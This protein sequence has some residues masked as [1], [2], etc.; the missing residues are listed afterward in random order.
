[1]RVQSTGPAAT[2][3]FQN[4]DVITSVEGASVTEL[5]PRGV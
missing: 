3:G 2:A 4:G 1:M 5:A